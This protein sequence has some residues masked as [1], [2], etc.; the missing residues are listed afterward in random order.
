MRHVFS[1]G[2]SRSGTTLL[3]TV[4]DAH[5]RIA[6]GYELL[7]GP[8]PAVAACL[9]ALDAA[10]TSGDGPIR[11]LRADGHD[12]LAKFVQNARWASVKV[13]GVVRLLQRHRDEHGEDLS[14]LEARARL[15]MAVAERK[16]HKTGAELSGF[17]VNTHRVEA[18]DELF[19]DSSFVLIV[20]D[21]RDVTASQLR[22]GFDRSPRHI[23]KGW[24]RYLDHMATLSTRNDATVTVRYE[25]LVTDRDAALDRIFSVTGLSPTDEV[26]HFYESDAGILG[27]RHNNAE[28]VG[29]DLF[30]TS[31]GRWRSEL[32]DRDRSTVER[33]TK[34]WRAR[35]GY[36]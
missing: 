15:A 12:A 6:L 21:P 11:A 28:R 4:L 31:V 16:R 17:K 33:T 1:C 26:R 13:G 34:E 8:L 14:T 19:P 29:Q 25:D 20:R 27:S 18:F 10:T 3:S 5:P 22:R 36:D 2:Y 35:L 30:T 9:D 23:A 24:V 7:P 32:S